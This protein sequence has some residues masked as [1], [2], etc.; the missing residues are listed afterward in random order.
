MGMRENVVVVLAV[1]WVIE[2]RDVQPVTSRIH[3]GFE[4]AAQER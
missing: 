2:R 4:I 3:P 1:C